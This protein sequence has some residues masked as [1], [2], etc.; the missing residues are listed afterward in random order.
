MSNLES[1]SVVD[2]CDRVKHLGYKISGRIR[3]YGEEYEVI[4]DPFL[5][6]EGVAVRVKSAKNPTERVLHL[7]ATV[8]QNAKNHQP[9]KIA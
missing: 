1:S 8:V 6:A 9:A 5:E 7:P 4:S 3:L 2:I